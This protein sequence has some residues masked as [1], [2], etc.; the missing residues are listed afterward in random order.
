M[1]ITKLFENYDLISLGYN[2]FPKLFITKLIKKETHLFDYVGSSTWSIL[3]LLENN[4]EN[5]L[6]KKFYYYPNE[7]FIP[8]DSSYNITNKE[9]YLRF[10]HDNDFLKNDENWNEFY[11][12]YTRRIN[13]FNELL[14]SDKNLL[15]FYLEDTIFRL[16]M[17]YEEI[18]QYYPTNKEN[19][20]IEQSKLEQ[21]RMFEIVDILKK[22]YNKYNFKIIYFSNLIEKTYYNN[23][24]IFIKT[25][26]HYS[27]IKWDEWAQKQCIKS[28]NDNYDYI[29]QFLQNNETI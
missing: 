19:Y 3:K 15:F 27:N 5:F 21:S 20:E 9:Y 12:K 23:N 7:T 14:K 25:D 4:F 10:I 26:C 8:H 11:N 2:C 17:L 22:K 29:T 6:N 24:I 1:N 13:R 28:I 16:E 18:K